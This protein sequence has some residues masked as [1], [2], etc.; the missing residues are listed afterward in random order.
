MPEFRTWEDYVYPPPD[1]M[2]LRNI[3]GIRDFWELRELEYMVA[4]KRETQLRAG[5]FDIP[6]TFDAEHIKAIHR[7]LF[8]DLYPWAGQLR[9]INMRRHGDAVGF[10]GVRNGAIESY[11]NGVREIVAMNDWPAMNRQQFATAAAQVFSWCNQSHPF[12]DGNGRAT[13]ILMDHVAELSPFQLDRSQVSKEA[14]DLA[15]AATRPESHTSVPRWEA[16]VDVFARMVVDRPTTTALED[17]A[18]SRASVVQAS[19]P[20]AASEATRPQQLAGSARSSASSPPSKGY[21]SGIGD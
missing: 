9:R 8:K 21:G 6:R 4:A 12:R 1:E 14:W 20:R 17:A 15:S 11:M 16:I 10:A 5:M 3:P 19:Y 7:H 18:A 13:R 2:T